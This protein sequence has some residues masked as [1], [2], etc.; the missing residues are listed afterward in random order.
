[1]IDC[2]SLH[3]FFRIALRVAIVTMHFHIAQIGFILGTL[4]S[5]TGYPR[6]QFGTNEKSSWCAKYVKI[7]ADVL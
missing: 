3:A 2:V 5:H 1:M 7:D 6:E 4:F